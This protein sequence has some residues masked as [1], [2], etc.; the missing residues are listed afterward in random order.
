MVWRQPT[1]CQRVQRFD[2]KVLGFSD[3]LQTGDAVVFLLLRVW[4]RMRGLLHDVGLSMPS[5]AKS[6]EL[7]VRLQ[8]LPTGPSLKLIVPLCRIS[9]LLA[10]V[11]DIGRRKLQEDLPG[12]ADEASHGHGFTE[13]AGISL[14][15]PSNS[16]AEKSEN[17][18]YLGTST[19]LPIHPSLFRLIIYAQVVVRKPR[20]TACM[21]H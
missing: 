13:F 15:V 9:C 16:T 8:K 3:A 1:A 6:Q 2:G 18:R 12:H 14:H 20:P 10:R 5:R 17:Q 19:I 11:K 4:A 21:R 7:H